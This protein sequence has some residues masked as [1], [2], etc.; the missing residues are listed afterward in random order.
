MEARS[1]NS[2]L[3][4]FD[5][6]HISHLSTWKQAEKEVGETDIVVCRNWLKTDWWLSLEDRRKDIIYTLLLDPD[7]NPRKRDPEK[8]VKIADN[9][10]MILSIIN[11]A[12]KIV[13]WIKSQE[14]I[15]YLYRLLNYYKIK[16]VEHKWHFVSVPEYLKDISSTKNKMGLQEYIKEFDYIPK[17]YCDLFWSE[18]YRKIKT[19]IF[20]SD[21]EESTR[22]N[23]FENISNYFERLD[24]LS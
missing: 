10:E 13:R 1:N 5:P 7:F 24:A 11:N 22:K 20:T 19:S 12:D 23:I 4:S 2:F 3:G 18:V 16:N 15:D 6:F 9:N 21:I 14:D 8:I 17:I